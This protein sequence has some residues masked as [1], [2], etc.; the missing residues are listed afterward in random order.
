MIIRLA[1]AIGLCTICIPAQTQWMNQA[2]PGIPRKADGKPDLSARAPRTADGKPDLSG[3]W[4]ISVNQGYIANIAA[5]LK[6]GDVQPW[7]QAIYQQRSE[8]LGKD[9]PW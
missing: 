7:A 9:D 4:N 2:T 1:L 5:D 6:P 8:N 3:M